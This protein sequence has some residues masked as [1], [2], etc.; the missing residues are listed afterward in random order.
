MNKVT[1]KITEDCTKIYIND[2]LHIDIK[3]TEL[4]GIYVYEED[5]LVEVNQAFGAYSKMIQRR[6]FIELYFKQNTMKLEYDNKQLWTDV[7][8]VLEEL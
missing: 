5:K 7:L 4:I 1:S 6:Y 2:I 3:D 8:K